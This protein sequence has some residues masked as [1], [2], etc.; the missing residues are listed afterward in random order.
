M[1]TAVYCLFAVVG[2][3]IMVSMIRTKRFFA[4]LLLTA[5][6]GIVALF[7]AKY[8]GGFFGIGPS[9]NA[10]TLALSAVGGIPGVIFLF[11][12]GTIFK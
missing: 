12:A 4:V 10:H 9:I 8:V 2:L 7:A 11:I 5:M 1:N 3:A 6:Q